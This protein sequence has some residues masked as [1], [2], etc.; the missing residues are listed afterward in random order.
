LI[1]DDNESITIALS[2]YFK[3]KKLDCKITNDGRH[4]LELIK[5]ESFDWIVLDLAMPDFTGYD[6][7]DELEKVNILKDQKIIVFT[8]LLLDEDSICKLKKSG[9]YS[10]QNKPTDITKLTELILR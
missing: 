9:I 7:I 6:I 4:A 5:H 1:I 8:A 2:K 3:L 10:I